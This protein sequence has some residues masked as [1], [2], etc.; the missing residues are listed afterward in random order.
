MKRII[1][2]K[3]GF[4][5]RVIKR[6]FDIGISVAALIMLSPLALL[7][8]VA[9]KLDDMHGSVFFKHARNGKNGEKFWVV[10][11]RTMKK[12]DCGENV[13]ATANTLTKVGKIIRLLSLDEIPQFVTII[14]GKMSF[15]GPRPLP[16]SYYEWFSETERRRFNVRPGL[17]GLSQIHGRAN[18]NWDE[19]FVLDVQYAD[20]VSFLLDMKIFFRTFG[21]ILSHKDV[22]TDTEVLPEDFSEYRR[23]QLQKRNAPARIS[24][25]MDASA[26]EPKKMRAQV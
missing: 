26:Y 11:F 10:K 12:E 17:T 1:V 14:S 16:L 2:H 3:A 6:L 23:R 25:P 8:M 19:R 4:Y 20:N 15:I 7:C 22:L 24:Q 21:V 5:E 18:L 9:I 13:W